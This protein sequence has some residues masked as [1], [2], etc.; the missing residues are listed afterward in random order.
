[1]KLVAHLVRADVRRFRLLLAAWVLIEVLSTVFTGLQPVLAGDPRTMPAVGLLGTVLVLTRWLGMIVIVA[2]VVQ[3][4]PLVGSDAFWMTRP[5]P[6]RALLASKV[7]LL[8]T[9]FIAV[10]A[11]CE[12]VLMAACLVPIREMV[13]VSLQTILFQSL[14]VAFV[15]ALSSLTRN[16]ARFVLLTGGLLA[17]LVLLF[18]VMIAVAMRDMSGGPRLSVVASRPVLSPAA[19]VV[20]LLLLITAA[21]V[22]VVVQYRTRTTRLSVSAGVAGVAIVILVAWMWPWHPRPLPVPEWASRETALRLVAESPKG[23]FSSE[24]WSPWSRSEG[25]RIG[26]ARL[27]L[28]GIEEGWLATVRLADSSMQFDDG[29]TLANAGNGYQEPIPFESIDDSPTRVVT[30]HVLAVGRVSEGSQGNWPAAGVPALVVSQADFTKYS[31]ASGTY[32]GRYLVDLDRV[33]IAAALP[34]QPGAEYRDRRRRILVDQVIPQTQS[35]SIRVRQFTAATMF[36]SAPL[37]QLSFYLRNRDAAEAVAGSP[38]GTLHMTTGLPSMLGFY[39]ASGGSGDG[40]NAT[41]EYI[42]FPGYSKEDAVNISPDWLSRAELVIVRTVQW[43]SVTRTVEIP[44][45]E[46]RAAPATTGVLQF[47]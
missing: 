5:I 9:T 2:L 19:D 35:A 45:F 39:P 15:M 11:L 16:L 40:F 36:D 42:T 4:H 33:E 3:A 32:R 34:L 30:R 23:E 24:H 46:I 47:R 6:P 44:G 13:P 37:P 20:S 26:R 1:M 8:G 7:L 31:A 17:S 28:S 43:G 41:A 21:V 25:W 38:G 10:P 22:A 12:M 18:S 29:V 27:R 14:W